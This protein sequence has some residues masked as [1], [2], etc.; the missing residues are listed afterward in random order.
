MC[1]EARVAF[2]STTSEGGKQRKTRPNGGAQR[3]SMFGIRPLHLQCAITCFWPENNT[4]KCITHF[5]WLTCPHLNYKSYN[6]LDSK[7]PVG[8]VSVIPILSLELHE[9]TTPACQW[10]HQVWD[11]IGNQLPALPKALQVSRSTWPFCSSVS[12]P[13]LVWFDCRVLGI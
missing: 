6:L 8:F 11:H 4:S 9:K 2:H 7:Y 1:G 5:S 13:R 3:P 12:L 10:S